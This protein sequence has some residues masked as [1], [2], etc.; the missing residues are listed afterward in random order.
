MNATHP[1]STARVTW[2]KARPQPMTLAP[3]ATSSVAPSA[4]G[5]TNPP[6]YPSVEWTA[7]VAPRRPGSALPAL[8]AV[9]DDESDQISIAYRRTRAA[10][11]AYGRAAVKPI[12][13][14]NAAEMSIVPRM[15][16]RRPNRMDSSLPQTLAHTPTRPMTLATVAGASGVQALEVWAATNV[17]NVTTQPRSADIS[18]VCTQYAIE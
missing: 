16:R 4:S 10:A 11:P 6:A 15:K 13:A 17:K 3:P 7:S 2:P 12:T 9:S 14:A 8:P 1:A 5:P 18:H